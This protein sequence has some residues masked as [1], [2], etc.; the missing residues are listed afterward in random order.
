MQFSHRWKGGAQEN[1]DWSDSFVRDGFVSAIERE[2][3]Y[4]HYRRE[5]DA[6][7]SRPIVIV[8]LWFVCFWCTVSTRLFF[9]SF[10]LVSRRHWHEE[11][12]SLLICHGFA[13]KEETRVLP[14]PLSLSCTRRISIIYRPNFYWSELLRSV[15]QFVSWRRQQTAHSTCN[16]QNLRVESGF[17]RQR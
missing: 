14:L 12:R 15:V 6:D 9:S 7:P 11:N 2:E 8:V 5:L 1:S 17:A 10:A 13:L 16:E 4:L 3:K